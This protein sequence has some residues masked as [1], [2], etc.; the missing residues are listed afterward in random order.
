MDQTT[1]DRAT[2]ERIAEPTSSAAAASG[3]ADARPARLRRTEARLRAKVGP[4]AELV[5]W[6]R[7]WVSRARRLHRLL[8]ARTL[9]YVVLTDDSLTIVSIGF[10]TRRPRRCV[11]SEALRALVAID[12][13]VP[14]GRRLR[15][16]TAFGPR[17][18]IELSGKAQAAAFADAL[19]A[20]VRRDPA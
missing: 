17:L 14:N 20:R 4:D 18:W 6:T 1:P 10:F 15:V 2:P 9:D 12:D 13:P 5:A 7:G 3:P 16:R 19:A 11:Y 8:A